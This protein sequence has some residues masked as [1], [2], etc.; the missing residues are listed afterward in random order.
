MKNDSDS[1][2]AIDHYHA[3][4]PTEFPR[5]GRIELTQRFDPDAGQDLTLELWPREGCARRLLLTFENVRDFRFAPGAWSQIPVHLEITCIRDRQW[6][7]VRYRVTD[8]EHLDFAFYC[9][10]LHAELSDGADDERDAF[11]TG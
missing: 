2:H 5:L 8:C 9:E 6:D 3:L 7:A 4:K 10:R 11:P 1:D